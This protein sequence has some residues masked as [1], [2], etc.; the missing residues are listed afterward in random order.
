MSNKEGLQ[1]TPLWEDI[2]IIVSIITLWPTVLNKENF[3][4]R[5]ILILA[6][7][8]L[9]I[10]FIRRIKRFNSAVKK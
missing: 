9:F 7:F 1:K 6:L 8:L 2:A 3:L 10:I 4:S 5:I